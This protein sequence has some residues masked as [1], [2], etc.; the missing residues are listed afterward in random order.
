[1][2][3][4]TQL[5]SAFSNIFRS[6]GHPG[7]RKFLVG[8]SVSAVGTWMQSVAQGLLVL[9]LGGSGVELGVTV[10]LQVI[11]LVVLSPMGG[12]W[13]DQLDRRQLLLVAYTVAGAQSLILGLLAASG[14]ATLPI[15]YLMA[16]TLGITGSVQVPAQQAFVGE[17]VGPGDLPNALQVNLLTINIARVFG[18]AIAG[19]AVAGFGVGVCFL[20][21]AASFVVAIAAV[22]LISASE[23]RVEPRQSAQ[24]GQLLGGIAHVRH[25]PELAGAWW[26]NLVYCMLAWQ[27]E[28][29]VPLL[30]TET[31]GG[32]A[33]TYGLMFSALGLGAVIGGA[34][35]ASR[36]QPSHRDQLLAAVIGG[37]GM[38]GTALA[39]N[40]PVAFVTAAIGGGGIVCWWGLLSG[41]FQIQAA[42]QFRARAAG[43]WMTGL[44]GGRPLGALLVG[45]IAANFGARAP[46]LLGALGCVLA[47]AVWRWVSG[48][49]LRDAISENTPVA[50]VRDEQVARNTMVAESEIIGE[51]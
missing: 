49:R 41:I 23:R 9:Q 28:V 5:R 31:F 36:P 32:S 8:L 38:L 48:H 27:F 29:S 6:V 10:M 33:G 1:M 17:L 45:W 24:R 15:V 12:V 25:N 4:A 7:Y 2:T 21:N 19:F 14:Q 26:M 37:A 22:A 42:P 18:P 44:H 47:I 35:G 16:F 34:W 50:G 3:I 40:L 46:F 51:P 20:L 30:V 11:P 39:P 43:L 13:A